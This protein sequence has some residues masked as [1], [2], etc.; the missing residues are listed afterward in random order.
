MRNV[1]RKRVV[2]RERGFMGVVFILL[3]VAK[4]K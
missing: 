2:R 1:E 4:N 3:S